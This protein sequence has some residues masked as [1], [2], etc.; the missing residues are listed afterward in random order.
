MPK[1][2]ETDE[3]SNQTEESQANGAA[4]QKAIEQSLCGDAAAECV[5]VV[6][7]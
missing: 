5:T 3:R 1:H 2:K 6:L 7:S 4:R